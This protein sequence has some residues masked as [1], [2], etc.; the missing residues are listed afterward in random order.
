MVDQSSVDQ[1]TLE[2]DDLVLMQFAFTWLK[3]VAEREVENK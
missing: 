1:D 2:T 3:T